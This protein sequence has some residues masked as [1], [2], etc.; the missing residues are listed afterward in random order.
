[1]S[2]KKSI[3][4]NHLSLANS[5]ITT[6]NLELRSSR[7]IPS[8]QENTNSVDEDD[9][10]SYTNISNNFSNKSNQNSKVYSYFATYE[11][12]AT[13][14]YYGYEEDQEHFDFIF[15]NI[16]AKIDTLVV[17]KC[18]AILNR[19]QNIQR[20]NFITRHII[21]NEKQINFIFRIPYLGVE[22]VIV[23]SFKQALLNDMN[24]V[25]GENTEYEVKMF[26]ENEYLE[27]GNPKKV[28]GNI[29]I[30]KR[31]KLELLTDNTDH[32]FFFKDNKSKIFNFG[33]CIF[34]LLLRDPFYVVN[35]TDFYKGRDGFYVGMD[36][37]SGSDNV[38]LKI[39]K[40]NYFINEN[41]S[42]EK[43]FDKFVRISEEENQENQEIS[44]ELKYKGDISEETM[45]RYLK[46]TLKESYFQLVIEE[47]L[48]LL[49]LD[50]NPYFTSKFEPKKFINHIDKFCEKEVNVRCFSQQSIKFELVY[51]SC[52][53]SSLRQLIKIIRDFVKK[54]AKI[55]D[56]CENLF[57]DDQ[58]IDLTTEDFKTFKPKVDGEIFYFFTPKLSEDFDIKKLS[59]SK[60]CPSSRKIIKAIDGNIPTNLINQ[61]LIIPSKRFFMIVKITRNR[62]KLIFYNLNKTLRANISSKI[63]KHIIYTEIREAVIASLS[64]R[65]SNKD[66][67]GL[68]SDK[69]KKVKENVKVDVKNIHKRM[70]S[71]KIKNYSSK[72]TNS[73]LKEGQNDEPSITDI[74]LNIIKSKDYDSKMEALFDIT[75]SKILKQ[76]AKS[77]TE[78]IKFISFKM[79][80]GVEGFECSV[81]KER[82][83]M[84]KCALKNL[85]NIKYLVMFHVRDM[86]VR[87]LIEDEVENM[88]QKFEI[89]KPDLE[90]LDVFS[91][92]MFYFEKNFE[93]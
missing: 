44:F 55:F 3:S 65:T 74:I 72:S 10:A 20:N 40:N 19:S 83:F 47:W 34:I 46:T 7:I 87:S 79:G 67:I 66:L 41:F 61:K 1:M 68:I 56:Y 21:E 33:R 22:Q 23:L 4:S 25:K 52:Y 17:Q 15:S 48:H 64:I 70:L 36:L 58:E 8:N 54:N 14:S 38:P 6:S 77:L 18:S 2:Y 12:T 43:E 11:C 27:E 28:K 92:P 73:V 42:F 63:I 5:K 60:N 31:A 24:M 90:L 62:V 91:V 88:F 84:E 13:I 9:N 30:P 59:K 71:L 51:D 50:V 75:K 49:N 81:K 80:K 86:R 57:L 32:L 29:R 39:E 93:N 78:A 53:H 16:K 69:I 26:Q 85:Q 82:N 89:V 35:Y 76:V 37:E 45:E